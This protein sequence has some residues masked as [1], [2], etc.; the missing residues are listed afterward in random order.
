MPTQK[1]KHDE[2]HSNLVLHRKRSRAS[3]S[4]CTTSR[5][6]QRSSQSSQAS[7]S[8]IRGSSVVLQATPLRLNLRVLDSH[9]SQRLLPTSF[10]MESEEAGWESAHNPIIISEMETAAQRSSSPRS[11]FPKFT[12]QNSL[13]QGAPPSGPLYSFFEQK[14]DL[15]NFP[16]NLD[17][18]Q[19][20]QSRL[21]SAR[22]AG[23]QRRTELQEKRKE[24]RL[25]R[26]AKSSADDSFMKYVRMCR[27]HPSQV[28][29][30]KIDPSVD[31]GIE[32]LYEAMQTARNEYGEAEYE[33]NQLEDLVDEIDF[34]LAKL[35]GKLCYPAASDFPVPVSK[36]KESQPSTAESLLGIFS[37]GPKEYHQFHL[38][39][40]DRLG[41]LDLARE[42][43][44]NM[45]QERNSLLLREETYAYLGHE[46]HP[47][48]KEFLAKFS[49]QE[50]ALLG[51]IVAI[52][53]DIE[54]WRQKCLVEGIEIGEQDS[55]TRHESRT[56]PESPSHKDLIE[57]VK[58]AHSS[59]FESS[60]FPVL[61]PKSVEGKFKLRFL[62][63]DFD[64]GNK[65]DRI[66]RWILYQ[67]Q[68]SLAEVE[69][70]TR[71]F[72]HFLRIV[73]LS[74]WGVDL[75][76][77]EINVLEWWPKDEAN[78]SPKDFGTANTDSSADL[79]IEPAN[80]HPRFL[81]RFGTGKTGSDYH[82]ARP[83]RRTK[84][85]PVCPTEET[86]MVLHR[87]ISIRE[88]RNTLER[89]DDNT[90]G[91]GSDRD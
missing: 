51:G 62:I 15:S 58:A 79:N 89:K 54:Y 63:T 14:D 71:T 53:E 60:M 84:S 73:D 46:L 82:G 90:C 18:I 75:P 29:F 91:L 59:N 6:L 52:E 43:Y 69:L 12:G 21:R 77:W 64:E 85:E 76:E 24:L 8:R 80:L 55:E 87:I 72:L 17:W 81:P 2:S 45:K 86:G 30:P 39:Y 44:Q 36:A 31:M 38:N 48:E 3:T 5:S 66:N 61:L 41:D 25:K 47:N 33:Y 34:E 22:I 1:P 28:E 56:N 23:L 40:L 88:V 37:D 26:L 27:L 13:H 74:Q 11:H 65:S 35:E 68:T 67:L 10:N 57:G 83:Y 78:K 16:A 19:E 7:K 70:L 4:S 50:A 49:E 20:E 42:R 32:A 9:P